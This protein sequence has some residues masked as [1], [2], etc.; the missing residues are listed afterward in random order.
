MDSVLLV[1]PFANSKGLLI[2][3]AE[4]FEKTKVEMQMTA[5]LLL[6]LISMFE[7][8]IHHLTVDK[9]NYDFGRKL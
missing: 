7:T 8:E 5:R 2:F 6:Q 1:Q 9:A 3:G 4:R